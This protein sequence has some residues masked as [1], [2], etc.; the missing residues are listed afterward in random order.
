ML[1]AVLGSAGIMTRVAAIVYVAGRVAVDLVGAVAPWVMLY[2]SGDGG[3]RRH[4]GYRKRAE[5][6]FVLC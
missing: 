5:M 4:L 1:I 2:L 3:F 6:R